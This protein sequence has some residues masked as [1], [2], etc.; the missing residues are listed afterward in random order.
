MSFKRP[1]EMEFPRETKVDALRNA[2]WKCEM[3]GVKKKETE[4]GFLEIH[5]ILPVYIAV[6]YYP[7]V[8]AVAIRSLAN[9]EV[10]CVSCHH[11][12]H[13][14]EDFAEYNEQAIKLIEYNQVLKNA[15]VLLGSGGR[16]RL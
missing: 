12:R 1:P 6:K 2:D 13:E 16:R 9:A 14:W 15:R 3:C 10:L 11:K 5:H 7:H 4:Q 8:S